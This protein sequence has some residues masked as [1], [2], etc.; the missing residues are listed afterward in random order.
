[1]P[2]GA[3][4]M[5][6]AQPKQY[7]SLEIARAD[8]KHAH[9][10]TRCR[11]AASGPLSTNRSIPINT[12]VPRSR[13]S[14]VGN[15]GH[16]GFTARTQET[17]AAG[18]ELDKSDHPFLPPVNFDDLHESI[19]LGDFGDLD[20]TKGP[21]LPPPRKQPSMPNLTSSEGATRNFSLEQLPKAPE[22]TARHGR[23]NSS[24]RPPSNTLRQPSNSS[25]KS[26]FMAPPVTLQ[27]QQQPRRQSY[28]YTAQS[29]HNPERA[30]RKSMG[31]G[32]FTAPATEQMAA[33]P[34]DLPNLERSGTGPPR[35]AKPREVSGNRP[36]RLSLA[37]T[38][39]QSILG[40]ARNAKAK[41]MQ[42]PPNMPS[43][44]LQ[45]DPSTPD[46]PWASVMSAKSP[47]RD[48]MGGP[49]TPASAK[50]MSMHATG[51]GA[52][53]VS[54]TDAR[55]AK[56]LSMMPNA[57]P[58]PQ[59]PP[60]P[61]P[62]AQSSRPR[63]VVESPS[64][65]PRKSVTPCS[66]RTTP[67]HHRK[68]YSSGISIS[69]NTSFNSLKNAATNAR[70]QQ[71]TASSRL[72][73]LKTRTDTTSTTGEEYVPPVPAIPKAF[74]SPK[75]ATD[76]G[77]MAARKSS[78]PYDSLSVN[79]GSTLEYATALSSTSS[80]RDV[81]KMDQ[82]PRQRQASVATMELAEEERAAGIQDGRRTMQPLRIPI[83]MGGA[84]KHESGSS[85]DYSSMTPPPRKGPPK[86]PSTPMTASKSSFFTR[87]RK[88]ET[89][90]VSIQNRSNSSHLALRHEG[91]LNF[92]A[93][94][95]SGSSVRPG[96]EFKP[97]RKATSPFVSSS[98]PKSSGEFQRRASPNGDRSTSTV[99]TTA[100]P[101]RLTGP[102]AQTATRTASKPEMPSHQHSPSDTEATSF[103]NSL[104]RKLSMTR[105][106]SSSKADM[107]LNNVQVKTSPT[108][109][110]SFLH[111]RRKSSAPDTFSRPEPR[112]TDEAVAAAALGTKDSKQM[113]DS[114]VRV[115]AK[116]PESNIKRFNSNSSID[117][118]KLATVNTKLDTSDMAAE[119][120]MAKLASKRRKTET[121]AR[122][123]DELRR[124]AVPRDRVSPAHALRAARL[125]I[126]ER[127]EIVD[128]KEIYFCGTQDAKKFAG[129]LES[130]SAN[131][132]YDDDRGD[133]NIVLG[134]HLSYRYEVVDVLGKGSFGQVVRCVD[135][136][137][138]GLV[139]IKIIRNKK[140]FHQQ[141]LVEVNILQKLR[142]WVSK[143]SA[144]RWLGLTSVGPHQ[145]VQ[146]GQ[147]RAE[148]LFPRTLVHLD[149]AAGHESL[150]LH[151]G[152]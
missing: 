45:T 110:Q 105:R 73:T 68:S 65:I 19:T 139:A 132:G 118:F 79:S 108:P 117:S 145:Q 15:A 96:V 86:T 9:T 137:T 67:D 71:N 133:Y 41:S 78:L 4:P 106:R 66:N 90:P 56:R 121:E 141:A 2:Q 6:S 140:R 7:V 11:T 125:N 111:S 95:S 74:D 69:S 43:D 129:N 1:M 103:G 5:A 47:G 50:R 29:L 134:D 51:L 81:V 149:R 77:F 49:G 101:S 150:R 3:R 44:F 64:L 59:T 61:L 63:S 80:E 116:V 135:H 131:F 113:A 62:T 24:A 92:R 124:R 128:F 104:R 10:D 119:E 107:Q 37:P 22:S 114:R 32:V 52:R 88:E 8:G 126:Y 115:S 55:R 120:E 76:A 138:G 151:Q 91:S 28:F 127:G 82:T 102:R 42:S 39:E 83:N 72:P 25:I 112:R 20:F 143:A 75:D 36:G 85:H 23:T 136:K 18:K 152:A 30:P 148:F 93:P 130:E 16:L 17:P 94:S 54:P 13:Q 12:K 70:L 144:W 122:E 34:D 87:N 40:R 147:L 48:A 14:S 31:P 109:K 97:P 89:A 123:L 21:E 100:R 146:H 58:V 99:S 33:M 38:T 142:E 27:T 35:Q 98:L 84:D 46:S 57:P 26:S 53:T 60:D